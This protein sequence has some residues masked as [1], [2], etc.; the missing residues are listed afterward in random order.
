MEKKNEVSKI[1]K[2]MLK[3]LLTLTIHL[4]KFFVL[5]FSLDPLPAHSI[6]AIIKFPNFFI[7]RLEF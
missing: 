5:D 3:I 6:I 1:L 7:Y 2:M 4:G